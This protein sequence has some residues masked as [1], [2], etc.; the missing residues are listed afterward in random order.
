MT[1]EQRKNL[2]KLAAYLH[3]LPDDYDR[4][5]MNTYLGLDGMSSATL[6][7]TPGLERYLTENGGLPG[8]GT[9]ACAVGHGPAA[10]VFLLPEEMTGGWGGG[11]VWSRYA[12]RVF[13]A[14]DEAFDW[15]FG[16]SWTSADNTAKGA[17]KRID[18]FLACGVPDEF[19]F[20]SDHAEFVKIYQ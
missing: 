5:N 14:E 15:M 2:A 20:E 19:D 8:C 17:A 3:A 9:V 7:D 12:E 16:A 6:K 18:Y 13:G 1:E 10:H 11:P 4:F